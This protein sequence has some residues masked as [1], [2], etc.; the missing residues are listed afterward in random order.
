MQKLFYNTIKMY[1]PSF[2]ITHNLLTYIASIEAS[3][4][5]IDSA[6]L[7]PSWEAKF[8][9]EALTR[10]V[11]FGT[12]IEGND[13]SAEQASQVI[14]L[15]GD[16]DTKEIS[17]NT[18]RLPFTLA[19]SRN[20]RKDDG[21]K[22]AD[23]IPVVLWGK[24]AEV[25]FQLLKKGSPVLIWGKLQ[26]RNYEKDSEKK[27]MTEVIAENFQ[28]LDKIKGINKDCLYY[29]LHDDLGLGIYE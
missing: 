29:N 13:L 10:T 24:L 7:V 20:Y 2:Q 25:G 14:H 28:I 22:E 16:F 4:A 21:S 11:H 27:W 18:S 15:K 3:K 17:E 23:F 19:V 26:V 1:Q 12:K 9:D 6:P 8:R 5:L